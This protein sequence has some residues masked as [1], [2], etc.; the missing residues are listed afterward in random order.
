MNKMGNYAS[1]C[2]M[3]IRLTKMDGTGDEVVSKI[4]L[5]V[6]N[7]LQA[8]E[9]SI[10]RML[11]PSTR[12]QLKPSA[13]SKP[14]VRLGSRAIKSS[15]NRNWCSRLYRELVA[16]I[17]SKIGVDKILKTLKILA[18][19]APPVSM[20]LQLCSELMHDVK[21]RSVLNLYS[22]RDRNNLS[23]SVYEIR[24]RS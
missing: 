16:V 10:D 8:K 7:P 22:F 2:R 20:G 18:E 24:W 9:V 17:V 14:S 23:N 1:H 15:K 19:A 13:V 12:P 6:L 11:F 21:H 4:H 5:E 3:R